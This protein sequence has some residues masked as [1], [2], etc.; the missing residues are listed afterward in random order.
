MD[1]DICIYVGSTHQSLSDRKA[2][3]HYLYRSGKGHYLHSYI[4][5]NGGWDM[6]TFKIISDHPHVSR[7]ELLDFEKDSIIEINPL[8]NQQRNPIRT[9]EDTI[10]YYRTRYIQ[11]AEAIKERSRRW[12]AQ[13]FTCDKCKCDVR[14]GEKSRH[15]RSIKH[16]V[17]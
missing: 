17:T 8:C 14:W 5:D 1:T 9:K 4:K 3:H 13:T 2:N 6:Y 12:A 10:E 15:L 16:N 11:N 7:T